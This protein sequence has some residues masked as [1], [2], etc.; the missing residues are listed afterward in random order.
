MLFFLGL[1]VYSNVF[2]YKHE[3]K[4]KKK[5]IWRE[6]RERKEEEEGKFS[7]VSVYQILLL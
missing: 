3:C 5:A 4:K 1:F 7:H 6:E 2:S